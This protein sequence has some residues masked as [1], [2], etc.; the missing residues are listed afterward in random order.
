VK[1]LIWIAPVLLLLTGCGDTW[2]N[3]L[4]PDFPWSRDR[5]VAADRTQAPYSAAAQAPVSA[6]APSA[7]S[8]RPSTRTA[9]AAQ[10]GCYR[11]RLTEEG[12]TCQAMRTEGGELMTLAGPLRGF[13]AGDSVCVCGIPA[14]RPFCNQGMTLLIREISDTYADIR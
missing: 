7:R 14:S 11:G 9:A 12:N 2:S 1:Q 13:G 4:T 6:G 3:F 5:S 10:S 8:Y